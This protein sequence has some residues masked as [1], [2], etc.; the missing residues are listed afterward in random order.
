[1]TMCLACNSSLLERAEKHCKALEM[2]TCLFLVLTRINIMVKQNLIKLS[3]TCAT[4]VVLL[5]TAGICV[6]CYVEVVS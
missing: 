2:D 5:K 4:V 3:N 6:C 1:M